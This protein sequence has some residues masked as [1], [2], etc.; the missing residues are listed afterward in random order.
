LARGNTVEIQGGA[1][2]T[3]AG[4][5]SVI[6]GGFANASG[7]HGS[8]ASGN[9]V[10]ISGGAFYCDSIMGGRAG[11]TS[12][13]TVTGGNTVEIS[14]GVRMRS[15]CAITGGHAG[16]GDPTDVSSDNLVKIGAMNID[17]GV[18]VDLYG[19]YADNGSAAATSENNTLEVSDQGATAHSTLYFQKLVFDVPATLTAGGTMLTVSNTSQFGGVATPMAPSIEIAIETGST[20]KKGDQI[21]LID[22]TGSSSPN[23]LV[24]SLTT[25]SPVSSK[26]AGYTFKIVTVA[27]S[28]KPSDDKKL[29]V[30]VAGAPTP[31]VFTQQTFPAD[32]VAVTASFGVK[33]DQDATAYWQVLDNTSG[34]ASCPAI[35]DPSY[36]ASYSDSLQ[37]NVL[38]SNGV[39]PLAALDPATDYLFCLYAENAD[40]D[41]G[42]WSH[43]FT[44][45]TPTLGAVTVSGITDTSANFS[46][47]ATVV[48]PTGYW[49]VI[50]NTSG[51]ATCP[52]VGDA[53]YVS[54]AV[55]NVDTPTVSGVSSTPLAAGTSYILCFYANYDYGS[56]I[57]AQAVPFKT[58]DTPPTSTVGPVTITATTDTTA[59][60]DVTSSTNADG[61]WQVIPGGSATCPPAG[62]ATYADSAPMTGGFPLDETVTGL[63][64]GNT[65]TVCFY[66]DFGGGNTSTPQG[67][68]VTTT[69]SASAPTVSGAVINITDTT[70]NVSVTYDAPI[71]GYGYLS[72]SGS[73]PAASAAYTDLGAMNAPATPYTTPLTGLSAGTSYTYC[74]YY[75]YGP[76]AATVTSAVQP[77][78]FT[79]SG[80]K[81][82][83][84]SGGSG[85]TSVPTLGE[86]TLALLALLLAGMGVVTMRR[87]Q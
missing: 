36:A 16:G 72:N 5:P 74:F 80:T 41:T 69:G 27:A 33:V 1:Y 82:P 58:L 48:G 70:A 46:V 62:D 81:A 63:A 59:S 29:V 43:N 64:A 25:A 67:V 65:Y 12:A 78:P 71:H 23:A 68:T 8:I 7:G 24:T 49:Q 76:A 75:T 57:T 17:A 83:P 50:D 84:S 21:V 14:T 6:E 35:G 2:G 28:G 66:A 44:T 32:P 53:S 77:L 3:G 26:T 20:L 47:T 85:A 40:G 13:K 19:G 52:A 60:F 79:T 15:H 30:E 11:G 4:S 55:L 51:A 37:A 31:P 45:A 42:I 38:Y 56:G 9:T 18:D 54:N 87:K 61:W 10:K 22:A 34:A 39:S 86:T 73:C